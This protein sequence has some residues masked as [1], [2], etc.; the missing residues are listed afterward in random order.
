LP[1]ILG[2][3]VVLFYLMRRKKW[4]RTNQPY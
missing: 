1:W 3:A 4:R 2:G